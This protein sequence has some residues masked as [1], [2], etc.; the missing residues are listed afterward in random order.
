MRPPTPLLGADLL[1]AVVSRVGPEHPASAAA[2]A[3]LSAD[4]T[5]VLGSALVSQA[6]RC[7]AAGTGLED[8][9]LAHADPRTLVEWAT[10][11]ITAK[12]RV[13]LQEA[14]AR[15]EDGYARR[16]VAEH[17]PLDMVTELSV[18]ADVADLAALAHAPGDDV[19][20]RLAPRLAEQAPDDA[21][22]ATFAELLLSSGAP[23]PDP[24]AATCLS[25]LPP[26]PDFDEW[27]AYTAWERRIRRIAQAQPRLAAR[28]TRD[29]AFAGLLRNLTA[30]LDRLDGIWDRLDDTT[31]EDAVRHRCAKI[32][33]HIP[34]R[35]TD[36]RREH[37]GSGRGWRRGAH[38]RRGTRAQR[39]S[40][41]VD[42]HCGLPTRAGSRLSAAER[43]R[44]T[45]AHR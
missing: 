45:G 19:P 8:A 30:S 9:L 25:L 35:G 11:G 10:A 34:R 43:Q 26:Q 37:P 5:S 42:R 39:R 40:R 28:V 17:L 22:G 6:G 44:R 24:V 21:D 15:V 29:P 7:G 27:D 13:V 3:G 16:H 38:V 31:L 4:S 14:W 18:T 33:V 41:R 20:S 1:A 12:P 36:P 32:D 2:V 23:L